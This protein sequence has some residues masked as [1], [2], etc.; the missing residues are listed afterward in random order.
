MTSTSGD[1]A[2][3]RI[4]AARAA[5]AAGDIAGAIAG[6]AAAALASEAAGDVALLAHALRHVGD[7]QFEAGD[8]VASAASLRKA[9]GHYRGLGAGHDLDLANTLRGLA[10]ATA[11]IDGP[12]RA[13][14]AWREARD[15]YAACGVDAGVVECDRRLAEGGAGTTAVIY[16]NPACGTSRNTLALMR[17]AGV[18]PRI[19]EYV[20][21]PP[22]REA[23]LA[24]VREAGIPLRAAVREKDLPAL[25]L[26][27]LDP[28]A[29]DAA[30]L[31]L[32]DAHPNLLQ[33][34]F[35]RTPRGVRLARPSERVLDILPP[36][37]TPFTKE[38]GEV[39]AANAGPGEGGA[40][41]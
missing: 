32:L 16:H 21:A 34:P 6:Y 23:L 19:V 14:D 35:V 29:T 36:I 20:Q 2:G 9:L 1:E 10:R 3:A 17:H 30:L 18:E 22:S 40:P 37:A 5:R 33:R 24:L 41:E 13:L 4:D 7:L 31:D 26:P 39:V 28:A 25:G 12:A 11:A 38:D 8:P 27:P 15:L